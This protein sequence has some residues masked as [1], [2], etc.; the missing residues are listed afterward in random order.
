MEKETTLMSSH[1]VRRNHLYTLRRIRGFRQKQ[2][3]TLLGYRGTSMISR[4]ESG[5]ALPSVKVALLLQIALGAQLAEIYV[6][7]YQELQ[8]LTLKRASLLPDALARSI[9]GRALGKD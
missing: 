6:D 9:R 5:V 1:N 7:L 4:F 8:A 2:L 3:A